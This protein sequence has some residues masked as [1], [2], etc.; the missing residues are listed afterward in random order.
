MITALFGLIFISLVIAACIL[1]LFRVEPASEIG[2]RLIMAVALFFIG[3]ML[4]P[5]GQEPLSSGT[6]RLALAFGFWLASA[7]YV[8]SPQ[9]VRDAGARII[10]LGGAGCALFAVVH[11]A[12]VGASTLLVGVIALAVIRILVARRK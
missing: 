11:L 1:S 10:L 2:R 8:I 12:G 4:R 5:G 7:A 9:T 3:T 6:L